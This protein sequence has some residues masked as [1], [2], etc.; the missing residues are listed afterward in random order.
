MA[1]SVNGATT[2]GMGW[3][4]AS[5][6][7]STTK[8]SATT[9]Y[10]YDGSGHRVLKIGPTSVTAYLGADQVTAPLPSGA[11]VATRYYTQSGSLVATRVGSGG[12]CSSWPT[13]GLG[14]CAGGL[15]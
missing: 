12:S 4:P 5:N 9:R 11:A 8:G 10:V 13:P 1:R 7:T 14:Q 3:D 2:R 6:L 15:G